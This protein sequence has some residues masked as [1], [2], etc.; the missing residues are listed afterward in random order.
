MREMEGRLETG[1]TEGDDGFLS[2]EKAWLDSTEQR[3]NRGIEESRGRRKRK[4]MSGRRGGCECC[5]KGNSA[6]EERRGETEGG[7]QRRLWAN[8]QAGNGKA[9]GGEREWANEQAV[10][11][12]SE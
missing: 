1:G 2:F 7:R 9:T 6:R 8:S 4:T 10:E 12:E 3:N 11:L 5:G